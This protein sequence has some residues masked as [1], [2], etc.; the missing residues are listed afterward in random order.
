[1]RTVTV[2]FCILMAVS[3]CNPT[4]QATGMG[5]YQSQAVKIEVV[6]SPANGGIVSRLQ[7][8]VFFNSVSVAEIVW[9]PR[10]LEYGKIGTGGLADQ[11]IRWFGTYRGKELRVD[12]VMDMTSI[13]SR[14]IIKYE[15]YAD[16]QLMGVVVAPF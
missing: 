15:I 6:D 14:P 9:D 7:S 4:T 1:M 3:G 12:R 11:Y 8:E 2:L 16:G 10:K 13:V 5:M